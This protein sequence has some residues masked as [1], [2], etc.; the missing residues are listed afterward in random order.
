[1]AKEHKNIT[2]I[3]KDIIDTFAEISQTLGYSEAHG[4]IL[5]ALMVSM[6]ELSLDDLA[7]KT[8]YST[9]MVSISLDLLEVLGI[10]KKIKKPQDRKLYVKM[11][12]D[13]LEVLKTAIMLKLG[14]GFSEVQGSFS[15]YREKIKNVKGSK[16]EKDALLRTLEKL[17]KET[18]RIGSYVDELSKV[19]IPK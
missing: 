18:L 4:R 17:E 5:A 10:V 15:Q 9:G 13:L 1:M 16:T 8:R 12:G 11:D 2:D 14:K 3:E 6:K 19:E 7:K